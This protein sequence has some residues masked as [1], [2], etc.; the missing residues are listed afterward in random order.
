[1]TPKKQE[2]QSGKWN[3]LD[4]LE[5]HASL[6]FWVMFCCFSLFLSVVG[7]GLVVSDITPLFVISS[8]LFETTWS[9][10]ASVTLVVTQAYCSRAWEDSLAL[11]TI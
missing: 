2:T 9:S 6:Y 8:A 1:M 7:I 10:L 11:G 4:H 3:Y 5:A